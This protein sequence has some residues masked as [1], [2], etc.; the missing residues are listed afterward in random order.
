V[1]LTGLRRSLSARALA[2]I[3][4]V[5]A[6]YLLL[7]ERFAALD[8][9]L[10]GRVLATLGFDVTRPQPARLLVS[11][12]DTYDVYAVVTGACSSAAG[13]LGI[14]AAAL[15]LL[16]GPLGR[17]A[18]GAAAATAVFVGLNVVRIVT[19]LGVGWVFAT[20]P[21][22]MLLGALTAIGVTCVLVA[23]RWQRSIVVRGTLVVATVVVAALAFDVA[24]GYDYAAVLGTYHALAG[25]LLT[26]GS[27]ALALL[28][29]F[30][31]IVGARREP[32]EAT[33]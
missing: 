28:V 19:I 7:W 25:P 33:A 27:L 24:R 15:I 1:S 12:G 20:V 16:P 8:T 5:L 18:F 23:W 11:A 6:G 9:A 2:T 13:A 32:A 30:R 4:V 14:A 29:L 26:F 31:T 22:R 21:E 10:V 3:G 17:R